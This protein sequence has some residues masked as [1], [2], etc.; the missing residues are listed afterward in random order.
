LGVAAMNFFSSVTNIERRMMIKS[1]PL[2]GFANVID[3][4]SLSLSAEKVQV[5]LLPFFV[6]A[7]LKITE[8][9]LHVNM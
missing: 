1:L 6:W 3:S 4:L 7:V 5:L 8:N 9:S 2:N